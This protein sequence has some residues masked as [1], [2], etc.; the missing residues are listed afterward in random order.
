VWW[1]WLAVWWLAVVDAVTGNLL[2]KS[3]YFKNV[4]K[5]KKELGG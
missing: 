3:K 2:S 1:W 5:Q 4:C